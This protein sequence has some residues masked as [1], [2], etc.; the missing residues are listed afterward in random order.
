MKLSLAENRLKFSLI[1]ILL[2]LIDMGSSLTYYF[3]FSNSLNVSVIEKK[4]NKLS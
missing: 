2:F 1:Y 3:F 4:V